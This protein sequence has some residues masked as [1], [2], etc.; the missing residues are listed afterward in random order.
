MFKKIKQL[1]A[2][3]GILLSAVLPLSACT[4]T[5]PYLLER[6]SID[7]SGSAVVFAIPYHAPA[8]EVS[9][10]NLSRYAVGKDYHLFV[11]NLAEQLLPLLHHEFPNAK[12]SFFADHSP[13]DEREAAA[14]GG[15]GIIGQNGL[16]ITKPYSSYVFLGEIITD[17]PISDGLYKLTDVSYCENCGACLSA[18]PYAKGEITECLSSLTQKKGE[19]SEK[20]QEALSRYGSVWG[21]DICQE[22]CPHTQEAD[23]HGTLSSPISFFHESPIPHLTY[24]GVRE[25]SDAEF[26]KRAYAWRGRKVIL[27]NLSVFEGEHEKPKKSNGGS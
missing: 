26:S 14:K 4:V 15:L 21:C 22:V 17:K 8:C 1:L 27:R 7:L 9:E 10:R 25:M 20:E 5:R 18:C 13:I 2:D 12:F 24:N 23:A 11:E 19:L 3:N 6:A 16:L